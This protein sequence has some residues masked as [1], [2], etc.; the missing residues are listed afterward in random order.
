M[1]VLA[2]I[3]TPEDAASGSHTQQPHQR[4]VSLLGRAANFIEAVAAF[5]FFRCPNFDFAQKLARILISHK[6]WL[7]LV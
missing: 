1:L 3:N 6:D 7:E 4:H 5:H 2:W